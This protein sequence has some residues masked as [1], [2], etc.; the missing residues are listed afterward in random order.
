MKPSI[1]GKHFWF[2]IHFIALSFPENPSQEDVRNY[3]VFFENLHTV[4]PCY[5][6]SLNYI[7]HLKSRPLTEK[8]LSNN[9]NLFNW[10]VD[11]HNITNKDLGKEVWSYD[12]ANRFYMNHE[13]F[14]HK[15]KITI[16]SFIIIIILLMFVL[17]LITTHYQFVY[18][19]TMIR[20]LF[21]K[22]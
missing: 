22:K 14:K 5:Q 8:D 21:L 9:S 20:D 3:Q 19:Y 11:I 17:S 16:T 2:T 18:P 4:L 7:K 12:R 10:T 6:C 13:N 15:S 1:W